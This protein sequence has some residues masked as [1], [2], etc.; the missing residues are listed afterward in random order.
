MKV[1]Q[2]LR[3]PLRSI[4]TAMFL[5]RS[6]VKQHALLS[7]AREMGETERHEPKPNATAERATK[8]RMQK[9]G[10][11]DLPAGLGSDLRVRRDFSIIAVANQE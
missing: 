5:G 2:G 6:L 9:S 11:V 7:K 1:V 8:E 3:E 4:T 10:E